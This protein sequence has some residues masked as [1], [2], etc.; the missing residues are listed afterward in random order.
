MDT[1]KA[2]EVLKNSG[3]FVDNL[4]HIDDVMCKFECT[5][6]EAQEVLYSVLT[7]DWIMEQIQ[8]A[9]YDRGVDMKLKPSKEF[10]E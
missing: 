6:D 7:D 5:E 4:W 10:G 8:V 3:C 1:E 9:I 2:K